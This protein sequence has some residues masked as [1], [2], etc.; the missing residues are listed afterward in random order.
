MSY[1]H[2]FREWSGEHVL[3]VV[4]LIQVVAFAYVVVNAFVRGF[5][6]ASMNERR[7][8]E[9]KFCE[10]M[11]EKGFKVTNTKRSKKHLLKILEAERPTT[12]GVEIAYAEFDYPYAFFCFPLPPTVKVLMVEAADKTEAA[13]VVSDLRSGKLSP[14][15]QTIEL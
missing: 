12:L 10:A 15:Y 14:A 5:H 2:S 7:G 4:L 11:V 3:L 8:I 9:G 13:Q 1:V 6:S